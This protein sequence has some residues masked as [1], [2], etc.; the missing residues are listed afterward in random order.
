M[1]FRNNPKIIAFCLFE[2]STLSF[3]AGVLIQKNCNF[4]PPVWT[5]PIYASVLGFSILSLL[6]WSLMSFR[7]QPFLAS[8]GLITL[9]S[10]LA[11]GLLFPQ[12]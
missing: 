12:L 10:L 4:T 11:A 6:V 9:L 2:G 1:Q 7:D 3:P 8:L 5:A